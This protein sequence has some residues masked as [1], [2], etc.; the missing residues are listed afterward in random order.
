[1]DFYPG[2]VKQDTDNK[3]SRHSDGFEKAKK[4]NRIGKFGAP[5]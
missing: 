1:M 4:I 5:R 2:Q 3:M